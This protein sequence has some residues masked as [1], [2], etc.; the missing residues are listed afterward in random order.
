MFIKYCVF[1]NILRYILDSLSRCQYTSSKLYWSTNL[2]KI[3]DL[4]GDSIKLNYK[5]LKPLTVSINRRKLSL[6]KHRYHSI[7]ERQTRCQITLSFLMFINT[8]Q[9]FF[10]FNTFLTNELSNL[11]YFFHSWRTFW[12][13]KRYVM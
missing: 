2:V 6:T 1:K 10:I 13:Q 5:K 4:R 9:L 8:K 12:F 3:S 11:L 7:S